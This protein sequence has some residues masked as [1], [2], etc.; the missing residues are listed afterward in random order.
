M[1]G[2]RDV[3]RS[4]SAPHPL[5]AI[6]LAVLQGSQSLPFTAGELEEAGC[7]DL[8]GEI[9]L[10]GQL[11]KDVI[12]ITSGDPDGGVTTEEL[13]F[14]FLTPDAG[15]GCFDDADGERYD[16]TTVQVYSQLGD[17]MQPIESADGKHVRLTGEGFPG[18]TRYHFA[19]LVLDVAGLGTLSPDEP[20]PDLIH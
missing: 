6:L 20:D 18:H 8:S 5:P 1:A 7:L 9:T 19:P 12:P 14:W 3:A 17:V 16:F 13:E 11:A 4:V 15:G 2:H 10:E